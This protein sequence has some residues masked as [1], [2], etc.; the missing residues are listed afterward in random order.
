MA[1]AAEAADARLA[2]ARRLSAVVQA[3][4]TGLSLSAAMPLRRGLPYDMALLVARLDE[5][6]DP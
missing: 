1:G 5:R 2:A 6:G 3:P 4:V